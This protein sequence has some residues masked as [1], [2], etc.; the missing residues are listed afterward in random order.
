MKVG[1]LALVLALVATPCLAQSG[2]SAAGARRLPA[3][4]V[5]VGPP[6]KP[7]GADIY[8]FV[9][10]PGDS[11]I[12]TVRSVGTRPIEVLLLDP[13]GNI[14]GQASGIGNVRLEA[15]A[16]WGDT[17][18]VAVIRASPATA[19]TVQR[20]T[21]AGTLEQFVLAHMA[22]YKAKSDSTTRCWLEPGKS[23]HTASG[24]GN[25]YDRT[26]EGSRVRYKISPL[27]SGAQ[28]VFFADIRIKGDAIAIVSHEVDGAHE[29]SLNLR[30]ERIRFNPDYIF[31]GY[32]C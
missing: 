30:P 3:G 32:S 14:V 16:S 2:D 28:D 31:A 1:I 24:D 19:Y 23:L 8:T 21:T 12:I 4:E 9:T 17:Y 7:G 25:W 27:S 15:I 13:G 11:H 18:S 26:I 10:L 29:T 5:L 20:S 6:G 22:G